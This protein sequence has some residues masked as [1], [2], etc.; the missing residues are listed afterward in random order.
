MSAKRK[1]RCPRCEGRGV[2]VIR[3]ATVNGS[4]LKTVRCEKCHAKPKGTK[5]PK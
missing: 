5:G 1:S 3:V 4:T 2:Y